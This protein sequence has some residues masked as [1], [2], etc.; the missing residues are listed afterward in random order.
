MVLGNKSR[1]FFRRFGLIAAFAGAVLG[2]VS[3]TLK[4]GAITNAPT[5]AFCFLILVLL[6]AFFGDLFT[7]VVTSAAAALCFNY[8]YLPPYGTFYIAAFSDWISFFAFL[9]TA[10]IISRLT[11]SAAANRAKA[12]SLKKTLAQLKEFGT[13]LLSLPQDQFTLSAIAEGA[14]RI[15][16]LAYCSIHVYS[17]GKWLHF[18][19]TASSDIPSEVADRLKVLK[20]HPTDLMELVEENALG[21]RYIQIRRGNAL[22]ALLAVK[23]RT[24]SAAALGTMAYMIG[25]RLIQFTTKL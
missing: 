7:A 17:E 22:M 21:V 24:L 3:L 23:S 4:Y 12:E 20:D 2:T 11:A 6:S 1:V 10:L 5:A 14:A 15:F 16:S 8:F 19:G 9:L 18:T 25:G 13:W